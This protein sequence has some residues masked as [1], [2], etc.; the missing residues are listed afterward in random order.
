MFNGQDLNITITSYVD[1]LQFGL[2][3]RS[4]GMLDMVRLAGYI[5]HAFLAHK[6]ELTS[7]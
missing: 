7:K 2:V 3:G 6:E 4:D 5:Q 1:A